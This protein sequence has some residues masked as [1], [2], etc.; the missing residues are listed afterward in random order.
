MRTAREHPTND[1]GDKGRAESPEGL[2][3]QAFARIVDSLPSAL[4]VFDSMSLEITFVNRRMREI[5]E[6]FG[7]SLP[8]PADE[9]LGRRIQIFDSGRQ[10]RLLA[11]PESL[12]SQAT[13]ELGGRTTD[14]RIL[15]IAEGDGQPA[16]VVLILDLPFENG[17][18]LDRRSAAG[19][20]RDAAAPEAPPKDGNIR[21]LH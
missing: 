19:A 13:I 20:P 4:I 16:S 6:A 8:Y 9:I 1:G 2:S 7:A 15:S 3:L 11:H 21:R 14:V 17:A 10:G 5:L 12:P 18:A